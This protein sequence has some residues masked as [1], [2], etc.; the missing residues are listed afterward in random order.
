MYFCAHSLGGWPCNGRQAAIDVAYDT[1][2][3]AYVLD[4]NSGQV[5]G[6]GRMGEIG[7]S[8][9]G[10]GD[11]VGNVEVDGFGWLFHTIN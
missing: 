7:T 6:T 10:G 9:R 3:N 11:G 1:A 4:V 5:S 2:Q 8:G